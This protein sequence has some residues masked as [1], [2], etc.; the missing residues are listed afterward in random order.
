MDLLEHQGKQLFRRHGIPVPAGALWPD[1]PAGVTDLVVKAQIPGGGRGK[2]GGIR[3]ADSVGAAAEAAQALADWASDGT[4]TT[5]VYLEARLEIRQEVYLA[6]AVD[7]DRRCPVVLASP[8]GGVDVE[9]APADDLLRLPVDPLLGLQPFHVAAAARRLAVPEVSYRQ[10]E[11]IVSALYALVVAEDATLAEINPLVVTADGSVLAA[12][13]KVSLDANAGFRR[14]PPDGVADGPAGAAS[15]LEADVAA[16]GA[17]GI[18]IDPAG[19]VV[20]VVSGAGLMMATLD[21]LS[22]ASTRLRAVVDLGGTVLAGGEA[23]A[24]VLAAVGAAAPRTTFLNAYLHTADCDQL[25]RMLAE[26]QEIAPLEGRVVVRL[27]GRNADA[28]QAR[29]HRQGFEVFAELPDA[30]AAVTRDPGAA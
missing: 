12:D 4:P 19:D 21:I 3:F 17:V 28:G 10:V 16:A 30:I 11:D 23:L 20:A 18:E 26:A 13:A 9:H 14:N 15:Q 22:A 5:G 1:T 25:A 6:V 27:K 24:R 2:R 7:R 8:H 29:L